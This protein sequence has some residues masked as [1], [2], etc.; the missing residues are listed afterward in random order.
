[1]AATKPRAKSSQYILK[2]FLTIMK[3]ISE[4]RN[5]RLGDDTQPIKSFWISAHS[6]IQGT[7]CC[8]TMPHL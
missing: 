3:D 8:C 2:E 4:R 6:G 7:T 1:M 5:E